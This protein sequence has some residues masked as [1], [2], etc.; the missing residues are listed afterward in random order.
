MTPLEWA[1]AVEEEER[2]AERLTELERFSSEAGRPP[3]VARTDLET[4]AYV[5][6][7]RALDKVLEEKNVQRC[8]EFEESLAP[9]PAPPS[10]PRRI[11]RL[12]WARRATT[13]H[14]GDVTV[15]S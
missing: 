4:A 11:K 10:R 7:T 3:G 12:R 14:T 9:P 2:L 13:V 8:E 15:G 5:A 1:D 6:F